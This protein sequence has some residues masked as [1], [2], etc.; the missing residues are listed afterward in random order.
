M[1]SFN[2]VEHLTRMRKFSE[3][4]FGPGVRTK[5]VVA[6]ILSELDEILDKPDDLSEWIDVVI[7]AFDRAW[8]AGYSLEE[9]V[10]ALLAKQ[11]K[12]EARRWPDWRTVAEDKPI[13]HVRDTEV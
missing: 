4:T 12:N 6:H 9:I 3:Q 5:G 1:D 10:A 7:L 11:A 2:L 13:E 8:R